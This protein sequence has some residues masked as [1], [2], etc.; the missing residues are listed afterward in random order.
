MTS[1]RPPSGPLS[2][3]RVVELVGLGPGPYAAQ[4]FAD[5]GAEVV[6]IDRPGAKPA[7]TTDRGKRSIVLDLRRPG[8]TE[9]VLRLCERSDALIEGFRP[10]VAE[11]LGLGPEAVHARA[12]GSVYGRMTGWGQTGPWAKTAGHDLNYIG[13][14]GAL[15]AMGEAGRPPVPPLN[16]VGDYGGGSLFLVMGLLAGIIEAKR[17]GRGRV[18]DAAIVDGA[19]SFMGVVASLGAMGQWSGER[20]DNLIDGGAPFYRCYETSDGR[21]MAVAPIEPQFLAVMLDVLGVEPSAYGAQLDKAEWPRQRALLE[22]VFARRTRD[23]W[24]EAFDGTDACVTPVLSFA[25][26]MDHPQNRARALYEA[27]GG[28]TQPKVAPVMGESVPVPAMPERGADGAAVLGELGYTD[29]EA[30]ALLSPR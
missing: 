25:E 4:L 7:F 23:E 3:I 24:A 16:F 5:L 17:T 1:A 8:A 29:E 10:G 9:A 11:R 15:A 21:W 30:A 18:V 19:A 12:P 26:A 27:R 14:T 13:L 20:E 6:S 2:G 22:G 28:L